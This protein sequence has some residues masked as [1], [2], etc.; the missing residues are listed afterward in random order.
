MKM[1]AT[2]ELT[3]LQCQTAAALIEGNSVAN[4][5]KIAGCS[6]LSI[7]RWMK[8]EAFRG[9]IDQGKRDALNYSSNRLASASFSA[10]TVLEAVMNDP[11]EHGPTRVKAAD[12]ILT[13]T[14]KMLELVD[15]RNRLDALEDGP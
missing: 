9:M 14:L 8:L 7:H 13:N 3:A 15:M 12:S 6:I 2:E 1:A 5:A 10:V 4:A 11:N